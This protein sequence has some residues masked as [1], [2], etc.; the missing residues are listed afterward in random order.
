MTDR[1]Y[2]RLPFEL[3]H[4]LQMVE[5]WH[6]NDCEGRVACAASDLGL[7]ADAARALAEWKQLQG[8]DVRATLQ[9]RPRHES[10]VARYTESLYKDRPRFTDK[11]RPRLRLVPLDKPTED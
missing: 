9:D 7:L 8:K 3:A 1:I 4:V 2:D 10:D 11:D 5:L 6:D